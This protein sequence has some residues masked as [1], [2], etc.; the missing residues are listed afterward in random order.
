MANITT[1]CNFIQPNWRLAYLGACD[2]G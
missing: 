1:A 2:F